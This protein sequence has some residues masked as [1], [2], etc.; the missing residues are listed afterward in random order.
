MENANLR[1]LRQSWRVFEAVQELLVSKAHHFNQGERH[2]GR[3]NQAY[4]GTRTANAEQAAA[5]LEVA[6]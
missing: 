2:N 3:Q 5:A 6:P 1:N 4:E